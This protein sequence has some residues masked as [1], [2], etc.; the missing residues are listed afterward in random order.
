MDTLNYFGNPGSYNP[1]TTSPSP[2]TITN[3]GSYNPVGIAS[4]ATPST[5]QTP[6]T[7]SV[8]PPPGTHAPKET[9]FDYAGEYA[10]ASTPVP[11]TPTTPTTPTIPT[12]PTPTT[13]KTPTTPAYDPNSAIDTAA[14]NMNTAITQYQNGSFPLTADEQSQI[15]GLQQTWDTLIQQQRDYNENYTGGVTSSGVVSGRSMYAPTIEM[16]NIKDSVDQGLTK[17]SNLEGQA[18]DAIAKMKQAFQDK[19]YK[20]A[21]DAY[22]VANDTIAAKS[23]AI[24]DTTQAVKDQLDIA[25]AKATIAKNA[26]DSVSS[27]AAGQLTGD[28]VADL[29]L[30]EG[31]AGNLGKDAQGNP[32]VSGQALYN[33]ALVDQQAK[34]KD[35]YT[36]DVGQYMQALNSGVIPAGTSYADFKSM[37]TNA[38]GDVGQYQSALKSGAIPAGTSYADFVKINKGTAVGGEGDINSN[39]ITGNTGAGVNYSD[40]LKQ[41]PG[42][43]QSDFSNAVQIVEGKLAPSELSKRAVSYGAALSAAN[44]YS[45]AT[46]GKP[47]DVAKADRDYKFANNVQTLNTLNYLSSLV[48]GDSTTPVGNLQQLLNLSNDMGRTNIPAINSAKFN[49]MLQT[50]NPQTVAYLTTLNE[51]GDQVAKILQGGGTGSGTSDAK[52]K[53]A[54]SMFDKGFSADQIKAVANSLQDLLGNRKSSMVRDNAYLKDYGVDMNYV[55]SQ[56]QPAT[57]AYKDLGSFFKDNPNITQSIKNVISQNNLNSTESLELING[58]S[59]FNSGSGGTPT[60]TVNKAVSFNDGTTGGQCGAFVNKLTGLGVGDS[61]QSK[62][63]KMD[64]SIKTPKPGMVFVMPYK[65]PGHIGI[66]LN[67]SNGMATVKDSNYSLNG[68]VQTHQIPV[69]KMT[70]FTYA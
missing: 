17:V 28:P 16:G 66:I 48:G 65:D 19:D 20:A 60:A 53:Q 37:G 52:L 46:T 5:A 54:M 32:I 2:S 12:T 33:A 69:S 44:L 47:F 57:T 58:L 55:A 70:G 31:I 34:L 10:K 40:I 38:S 13:P 22:K 49:V 63:S 56:V 3:P 27:F 29:K 67:V 50:G 11:A 9:P 64:P 26:I 18:A 61:Y 51:V 4:P 43:T 6:I 39:A 21:Q 42:L 30:M 14:N 68:K 23:Q 1:A 35:S 15:N 41:V 36:G 62:M 7:P 59:G 8:P 25:N 24:K 45:M